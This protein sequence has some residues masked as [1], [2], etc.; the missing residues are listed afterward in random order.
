[1]SIEQERRLF[2]LS[3]AAAGLGVALGAGAQPSANRFAA[4]VFDG[5]PIFD[6]RPVAAKVEALLPGKGAALTTAWR[7][8]QFEYQWLHALSNTY[9][10]FRKATDDALVFAARSID[11]VLSDADRL[12]L[13]S[14]FD[15]LGVWPD[16]PRALAAIRRAGVNTAIL[17]NMTSRMLDAGL[18]AARLSES[19]DRVL[20][21]DSI[22]SYKPDPASYQLAL[23][24]LRLP[25]QDI[26]FVAFAGWDAAGSKAFG[27]PTFWLNRLGAPAEELGARP[28]GVG[29]DMAA[30]LAF[31]GIPME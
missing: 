12:S 11:V 16:V 26:L 10:D 23:D 20:S 8:R 19:F 17:S 29:R 28:D 1:M 18:A 7:T 22:R 30:V 2:M 6:L 15:A 5:F 25:R 14:S 31:A 24:A 27:F 3:T 13:V 9:V 4:V 21:T